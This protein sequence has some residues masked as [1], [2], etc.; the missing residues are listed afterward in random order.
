MMQNAQA[1]LSDE[2]QNI[3]STETLKAIEASGLGV[4]PQDLSE[5]AEVLTSTREWANAALEVSYAP[6]L[7][8]VERVKKDEA[9]FVDKSRAKY[10]EHILRTTYM[11][12]DGAKYMQRDLDLGKRVDDAQVWHIAGEDHRA[13]GVLST[14]EK[15]K[16]TVRLK[17]HLY[18][19]LQLSRK[20]DW[21]YYP[22][23]KLTFP[24][25]I[26]GLYESLGAE[27]F[28][29]V[30]DHFL[31]T[32][33]GGHSVH[34]SELFVLHA[35][36]EQIGSNANAAK[37]LVDLKLERNKVWVLDG[38]DLFKKIPED[39]QRFV[40]A[41]DELSYF[42]RNDFLKMI[43]P[44]QGG[45]DNFCSLVTLLKK[46]HQEF[47]SYEATEKLIIERL[48]EEPEPVDFL[49]T[50]LELD[51][52]R[53][54]HSHYAHDLDSFI[55]KTL[56][57][58][59]ALKQWID[60]HIEEMNGE[61]I[62]T[63]NNFDLHFTR[64][65]PLT[66]ESLDI[67][68]GKL[69][70]AAAKF[71]IELVSL[72]EFPGLMYR[73]RTY[74]FERIEE[75]YDQFVAVFPN[76]AG[77][78]NGEQV[79]HF[80][81]FISAH[82]TMELAPEELSEVLRTM[83]KGLGDLNHD[84]DAFLGAK[85]SEWENENDGYKASHALLVREFHDLDAA[86][87]GEEAFVLDEKNYLV[88]MLAFL[89][90]NGDHNNGNRL[91]ALGFERK[92]RE[93][94][95]ELFKKEE[96]KDFCL[97]Q[98]ET[99]WAEY[100]GTKQ[101]GAFG[102]KLSL[103]VDFVGMTGGAG[104]LSQ[105]ESLSLFIYNLKKSFYEKSVASRTGAETLEGVAKMD[106]R[107]TRERWGRD[108]RSDYYNISRD[109]I[110][111]AP[112][113]Y[114]AF[115][116]VFEE[117][118]PAQLKRFFEEVY[119]LFRARLAVTP[120]TAQRRG[121]G[122]NYDP[123]ELVLLRRLLSEFKVE[124]KTKMDAF[125]SIR[126]KLLDQIR[127]HFKTQFGITKTPEAF[128]EEEVRSML[129]IS[130]YLANLAASNEEKKALL[131]WYLALMMDGKWQ[132]YRRGE[133]LDPG[134]YLTE[135]RRNT[136]GEVVQ[137]RAAL[138]PLTAERLG[139]PAEDIPEF[140]KLLQSETSCLGTG[141]VETIDVKLTNVITNLSGLKDPDLYPDP[142]DKVR[143]SLLLEFGNKAVGAAAAKFYR[144]IS[145]PAV[146]PVMNEEEQAI[147]DQMKLA[148]EREGIPITAENIKK[149][150]QESVKA[151]AIVTNILQFTNDL[152][153]EH[154]IQDLQKLLRPSGEAV[155]IF[156]RLGEEFNGES[157]AMALSQ[158]L[159]YLDNL[160][161]KRQDELSA[162]ERELLI[163]YV[164]AIRAELVKLQTIY[165]QIKS[166]FTNIKSAS[167][168][169]ALLS[170]K[171]TEIEKILNDQ[172]ELKTVVSTMTNSLNSIIENIRECLSCKRQGCNNDTDLSFGDSNKFFLFSHSET[173]RKGSVADQIVFLE[174][175]QYEDGTQG[176]AF[177]LD[178]VYGVCTPF[179]LTNHITAVLKKYEA[180]KKKFPT[181]NLSVLV[182]QASIATGGLNEKMLTS[183]LK[184]LEKDLIIEEATGEVDVVE[185]ATGDHYVEFGGSCRENGKRKVSGIVIKQA[186]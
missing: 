173:Q 26:E 35:L 180:I 81:D 102:F 86:L 72:G 103:L 182:S 20:I 136:V 163:N 124:L 36:K 109:L 101:K 85:F 116:E 150:F 74:D 105:F 34:F 63:L 107:F 161:V 16:G 24:Q 118:S 29:Q 154:I 114:A 177:V 176:L 80:S 8:L 112:S 14:Y 79:S 168:G 139:I 170:G 127:E 3:Y 186:S 5:L 113:L 49:K 144:S 98:L 130:T 122:S 19:A 121:E 67:F 51:P 65:K 82:P 6:V 148:L 135:E 151:L 62:F 43:P 94:I 69:K 41:L 7:D 78:T 95:E 174:P 117:L 52:I 57:E 171:I 153:A 32:R 55:P 160:I 4:S 90:I 23:E 145:A 92:S 13:L 56:G 53:A 37:T 15:L 33:E 167:G 46:L 159:A 132:A 54:N 93:K 97:N 25:I 71:E 88:L 38:K 175:V 91:P 110:A 185:S 30:V 165:D 123:R 61:S 146:V 27:V 157:G 108:E 128:G 147:C 89:K 129:N 66:K 141:E 12:V 59:K 11:G 178:R 169:N 75:I 45:I 184:E 179:I 87:S 64:L 68:Y 10:G 18:M 137:K 156:N 28:E 84:E 152:G 1:P 115:L 96:V 50:L 48:Q 125:A 104:H 138:S 111:A 42:E 100:L 134:E 76:Q 183:S 126:K 60:E 73:L 17:R 162:E 164:S 44:A 166:K 149:H 140:Q 131:G 133:V 2:S 99:L 70:R 40:K 158:D 142:M 9:K 120:L 47:Q 31:K 181:C 155:A 77:Q 106:A 172:T 83:G 143:L 58:L 39:I 22:T 21:D 119:P